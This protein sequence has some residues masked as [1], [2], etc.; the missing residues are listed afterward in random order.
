MEVL[1]KPKGTKP[2]DPVKG[3]DERL[4]G[5]LVRERRPPTGPVRSADNLEYY[6]RRTA[7][8]AG[9]DPGHRSSCVGH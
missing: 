3:S 1:R 7:F 9:K 6:D 8:V 4:R 5:Q 2:T